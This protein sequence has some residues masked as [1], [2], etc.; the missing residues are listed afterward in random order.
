MVVSELCDRAVSL[1]TVVAKKS[2]KHAVEAAQVIDDLTRLKGWAYPHLTTDDIVRVVRCKRCKHYKKYK[3][4]DDRKSQPFWACSLT[5]I[6]RD[7][8]FYCKDGREP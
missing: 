2:A 1:I 6:K 8:D 4:K 5:K 7:P 3:K